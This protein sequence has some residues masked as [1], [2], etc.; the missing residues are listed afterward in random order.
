MAVKYI[1]EKVLDN[2][3]VHFTHKFKMTVKNG[4]KTIIGKKSQMT[5][6]I[7][8]GTKILLKSQS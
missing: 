5:P 1:L 2:T 8:C 3:I 7:P 4:W 6:P